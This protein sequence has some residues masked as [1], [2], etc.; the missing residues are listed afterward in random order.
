MFTLTY[1]AHCIRARIEEFTPMTEAKFNLLV[2]NL[3]NQRQ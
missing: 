3:R 2:Q 1:T